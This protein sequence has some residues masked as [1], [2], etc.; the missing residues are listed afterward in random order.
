MEWPLAISA[1]AFLAAF[2]WPILNVDLDSGWRR[3]CRDVD[4]TAWAIFALDY[5]IRFALAERRPDYV[6]RHLLNLLIIGLPI[7]RPL[8]LL[9]VL[10]LLRFI[11]RRA[12]SSLRGR[13]AVYVTGS[14]LLVPRWPNSMPSG[15]ASTRIST[16]S[17]NRCGGP[18]P[19][20]PPSA[21][22]TFIRSPRKEAWWRPG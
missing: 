10:M 19:P 2:A 16:P 18:R 5:L 4:Y 7:L 20:S 12:T 8:R 13:V 6:R 22:A 15:T 17:A 21:T 1:L 9:R 11:N 3:L 14:T